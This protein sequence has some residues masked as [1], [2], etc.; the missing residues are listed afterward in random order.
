MKRSGFATRHLIRSPHRKWI[1]RQQRSVS[2]AVCGAANA[3]PVARQRPRRQSLCQSPSLLNLIGAAHSH[4]C[5]GQPSEA[6]LLQGVAFQ[7]PLTSIST[8]PD[9]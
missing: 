2:C 1:I 8:R 4:I 3:A 7:R 6:T 5:V 9:A